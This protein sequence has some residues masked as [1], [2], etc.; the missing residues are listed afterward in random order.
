MEN[1]FHYFQPNSLSC[2]TLMELNQQK[3]RSLRLGRGAGYT[4]EGAAGTSV[5]GAVQIGTLL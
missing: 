5:E 4:T 2:S 3:G 1:Y